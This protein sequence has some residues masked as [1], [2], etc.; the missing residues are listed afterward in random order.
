MFFRTDGYAFFASKKWH[1]TRIAL[2]FTG[3]FLLP[4]IAF[5]GNPT[6]T[7]TPP[8]T[9]TEDVTYTYVVKAEDQTS[10]N[11]VFTLKTKP[12]GMTISAT[13]QTSCSGRTC[14]WQATITWYPTNTNA[15]KTYNVSIESKDN[16]NNLTLQNYTL[17]VLNVNDAPIISSTAIKTATED[18]PYSYQVTASD[19]DPTGDKLTYTLQ[20]KPS[21]MTIDSSGRI[22]WTPINTQ[23]GTH[24][25]KIR[26]A[27][28]HGAFTEQSY[29]LT[30]VNTNDAPKITSTPPAGATTKK[31]YTYQIV[32]TDEDPTKDTL[33]YKLITKPSAMTIDASTGLVQWTPAIGDGNKTFNI[34][35]EVSDG[36]GGKDTQSWTIKVFHKNLSPTV[37]STPPTSTNEDAAYT[38]TIIA[39]DPEGDDLNFSFVK[40]TPGMTIS[41]SAGKKNEG[42]VKWTPNNSNVGDHV[43]KIQVDDGKGGV[44]SQEYTL[45]VKN[46]NDPPVITSKAI[47][48]AVED[49]TYK[50]E[51]KASDIDPTNDKLTFSL[52]A[53]PTGMVID[54]TTGLIQWTPTNTNANKSYTVTVSVADGNGGTVKQTYSLKVNNTNDAPQI[55]SKP[56]T[57]ATEDSPYA[58]AVKASD[59]DPTGDKLTYRLTSSPTGMKISS[60][61][62]ITWTPDNDAA[63]KRNH[64]VTIEVDD[65]KGKKDIQLFTIVVKNTNDPPVFTSSPVKGAIVGRAYQ[66]DA[67]A[68]DPDPTRDTLTFSLVQKPTGMTINASTGLIQWTPKLADSNKKYAVSIEV[69]DGNGGSTKQTFDVSVVDKNIAPKIS[70]T[71][72]TKATE[73][74]A[75]SYQVKASDADKDKLLYVLEVAPQ[76]MQINKDTGA[77]TWT[78]LNKDVKTHIVRIRVDDGKGGIARQSYNLVVANTNDAPQITSTPPADATED[79]LY[80]YQVK[81]VDQDPTNDKL[82]YTLKNSPKGMSIDS[83][84]GVITWKPGNA[85]VNRHQVTIEVTDG[86]GGKVVQSYTLTVKNVNDAPK[87]TSKAIT[88]TKEDDVYSYR[89][90]AQDED[91]SKDKLV[92]KLLIGPKGMTADSGTGLVQWKPTNSDVGTHKVSLY[93]ED[94]NGGSD[95]QT[96]TLTVTNVNDAPTITSKP[97]TGATQ[98]KA[99]KY[100]LKASDIDPTKDKLTFKLTKSPTGMVLNPNT[101][102]LTWTPTQAVVG[103]KQLVVAEVSDGKGGKDTQSWVIDVFNSNDPPKLTVKP[104]PQKATEDKLFQYQIQATDPDKDVLLYSLTQS[105]KGLNINPIRGLIQWTPTNDDVGQHGVTVRIDD[106]KGG[107]VTHTFTVTVANVNDKPTISSKPTTEAIE[108]KL[109]T[110]QITASDIDPTKDTLAYSLTNSPKGMT[111]NKSSGTIQWTPTNAQVGVHSV[112]AKVDDGKGGSA[113]Q[114]FNVTV[115]NVNDAPKITST[116]KLTAIEKQAYLYLVKASDIDP[117]ND[118]LTFSLVKSPKGMTIEPASG[119]VKWTPDNKDVGKH[120][121]EIKVEDGNGGSDKQT[122]T[123]EVRNTNDPPK[124]TSTPK[125]E[126]MMGKTY[127]Y[128]VKAVDP[129]PGQNNL[130]YKLLESPKAMTIDKSTGLVQWTPTHL[131]VSTVG[132]PVKISV[133]DSAGGS[134]EQAFKLKV[135]KDPSAPTASIKPFANIVPN[136]VTMDGTASTDP[137]SKPIT[138]EWTLMEGPDLKAKTK[139]TD[140]S[141]AQAVLRRAGTYKFRL[142]VDN[143]NK[144]S[145]PAFVEITVK[146]VAPVANPGHNF[147]AYVGKEIILDGSKSD[148]S[149]GDKDKLTYLW[150][151]TA[152]ETTQLKDSDKIKAS[153]TPTK[154]GT[155]RFSLVAKDDKLSSKPAEIQVVVLDA[156]K[157]S[158]PPYA[159]I[160]AP[161][162]A[163]P[164]D[165]VK[166]DASRSR[167]F[168][169]KS[170]KHVWSIVDGP[171]KTVLSDELTKTATFK[172]KKAGSYVIRLTVQDDVSAS[173]AALHRIDVV[174]D[175]EKLPEAKVANG[176][177]TFETWYTMDGTESKAGDGGDL[178][179]TWTQI[180]G[181]PVKL[182][183]EDPKDK[184]N[185]KLKFFALNQGTYRFQLVVTQ[186]NGTEGRPAIAVIR[187][188]NKEG[189]KPPK[190]DAGKSLLGKDAANA[191]TEVKLDGSGSADPEAAKMQYFWRQV[192]G[193]P[194]VLEDANTQNPKFMPWTY[195]VL[196]FELVVSDGDTES[197]P[198]VTVQVATNGGGNSI[199]VANAGEDQ[200]VLA[201]VQIELDGSGSTDADKDKLTYT[202][203][204][205]RPSEKEA[206]IKLDL[207]DPIKPTFK[208]PSDTKVKE[209][210]FGL[211]VDDGKISSL[212]DTVVIKVEG[213]NEAPKAVIKAPANVTEGATVTLDGS[214]S[215]DP[216]PTDKGDKGDNLIY[217]WAEK[218]GSTLKIKDAEKSKASFIASTPGT[219]EVEL[220]VSDGTLDNKATAKIV[221]K[222]KEVPPPPGCGCSQQNS[223]I[224]DSS[225]LLLLFFFFFA[226]VIRR[227]K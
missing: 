69:K 183:P 203:R 101:G 187:V 184:T 99:Y 19:P 130:T 80:T 111:I 57:A 205:L 116:A 127:T 15:N 42:V 109:Y 178:T 79:T 84:T 180:G 158:Y 175:G 97:P 87:F 29:N 137:N 61:G 173:P 90:T 89:A 67:N 169:K 75:Y 62:L 63:I 50:Y 174:A 123:L 149:N 181:P 38:Y 12:T 134:D 55:T 121:V 218:G 36:K 216:N 60:A 24:S 118:K 106:R 182:E 189:N 212:E 210:E 214:G 112:A 81:A 8:T 51:V 18:K 5:A 114:S 198:G 103:T 35:A 140:K 177:A 141:K 41:K 117:T 164:G 186:K 129:D 31:L 193:V 166:L 142:V 56:V 208:I 147:A 222:P 132:H 115:K 23:V 209:F 65:G 108:D 20:Q 43:I 154:A 157:K 156:G 34:S 179:Y 93:V 224:K 138:Y 46:T 196:T 85:D 32:A 168:A 9:A 176:H 7:T 148:D 28:P 83:G 73:D 14:I 13:T 88:T 30:V 161:A 159:F 64:S 195:T 74:T 151:Q 185:S 135:T 94:G 165:E 21:G 105:P 152:G 39:S 48:L 70:S 37:T 155:Y 4:A 215:T 125:T 52:S 76:G 194:V 2:F 126:I 10:H 190:A 133:E 107:I 171:D 188:N 122:F 145:P 58:Y 104:G 82:T 49:Q 33:T 98:G 77:I 16:K 27:D 54:A 92:F 136:E 192:G 100:T 225:H 131:D 40:F 120:A 91:P 3:I 113:L 211:V 17:N 47:T 44:T 26:V 139:N 202:W 191:G 72:P 143:S 128:L 213:V 163:K 22:S 223:P 221:V 167:S 204:L 144:K 170:L 68:T 150:K 45:T 66:Y 153:F 95:T 172:P 206:G 11:P 71:A 226:S 197:L 200:S 160:I 119:L 1:L 207:K 110:Y 86:K 124:I 220:T 162:Q 59:P 96:Y 78:P 25:V 102:A 53:K 6:F 146:N 201:G 217:K 227:K 199:P 219:Y